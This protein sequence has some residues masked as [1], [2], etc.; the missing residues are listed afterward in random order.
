[1]TRIAL[2]D[3]SDTS[4]PAFWKISEEF[5]EIKAAVL[6]LDEKAA[7]EWLENKAE[8]DSAMAAYEAAR[9]EW[10]RKHE[11]QAAGWLAKVGKQIIASLDVFEAR[12]EHGSKIHS[13][14]T[15]SY[16]FPDEFLETD[17]FGKKIHEEL[18]TNIKK[19]FFTTN[20][21]FPQTPPVGGSESDAARAKRIAAW[22]SEV[23]EPRAKSVTPS[24]AMNFHN[25][26]N[27][28]DL[29][30]ADLHVSKRPEDPDFQNPSEHPAGR[31][32]FLPDDSIT[33]CTRCPL[34]RWETEYMPPVVQGKYGKTVKLWKKEEVL[35]V[36]C[37]CAGKFNQ[38]TWTSGTGTGTGK[39]S[40]AIRNAAIKE[41]KARGND[42]K[43]A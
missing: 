13:Y 11:G 39:T 25:F 32:D 35:R 14:T 19:H 16:V 9:K 7:A 17:D 30:P 8:R 15:C 20:L 4:S 12:D 43:E 41:E 1:M 42:P 22:K 23:V 27:V 34:A 36:I 6:A 37:C 38:E 21:E 31:S 40:C 3:I 29:I 18:I 26:A 2:K 5:E 10:R 33:A 24:E 28:I